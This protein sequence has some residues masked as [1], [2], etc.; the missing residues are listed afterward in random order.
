MNQTEEDKKAK[1]ADVIAQKL[2]ITNAKDLEKSDPFFRDWYPADEKA[3][4]QKLG[5]IVKCKF[6]GEEHLCRVITFDR[7]SSYQ[8]EG[9]FANIAKLRLLK[10][11][12]Y[13]LLPLGMQIKGENEINLVFPKKQSLYEVLHSST[14]GSEDLTL[15]LA[16]KLSLLLRVARILNTLHSQSP[17]LAHGNLNSHNLMLDDDF[18]S[19]PFVPF[20]LYLTDI[21]LHDFQ[22]YAN[23]FGSYRCASVWSAPEVLKQPR[24]KLDP[25][26]EMDVYSFGMLMWEV[27]HDCVPFDGDLKACTDYVVNSDARPKIDEEGMDRS[28]SEIA[29]MANRVRVNERIADL[30]RTCWQQDPI[31]RPTMEE[32]CQKLNDE[33]WS[34][35][36]KGNANFFT[37][38]ED[39]LEGGN[40]NKTEINTKSDRTNEQLSDNVIEEV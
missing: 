5:S 36:N 24:K 22:K 32:V 3:H 34:E 28:M 17:P 12:D 7:I 27:F 14:I 35:V 39:A 25:T 11:E 15:P 31:H 1:F 33:L 8:I 19:D 40:I 6:K 9:Y 16:S 23:L 38:I 4:K 30:I 20:K 21:E 29:E 18:T 26:T 37:A 10:L 2:T 13:T